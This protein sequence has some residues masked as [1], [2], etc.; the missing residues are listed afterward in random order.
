VAGVEKQIL[1]RRRADHRRIVRRHR[2]QPGP[3]LRAGE[4]A[5]RREEVAHHMRERGEAR[6]AQREIV[7]AELGGAGGAQPLA[8]PGNHHLIGLVGE[9][10]LWRGDIVGNGNSYRIAL[11]R[12]HRQPTERPER[13]R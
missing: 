4:I 11:Y 2:A 9:C 5:G 8:E 1:I 3:G 12:I 13:Q 7:A 6:R 10:A